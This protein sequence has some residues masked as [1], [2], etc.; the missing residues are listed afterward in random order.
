M[1]DRDFHDA[2]VVGTGFA[3]LYAL[4][5]VK[6]LGLDVK[7]IDAADDVGGTWFCKLASLVDHKKHS[8]NTVFCQWVRLA[9]KRVT[10]IVLD[11]IRLNHYRCLRCYRES[12]SRRPK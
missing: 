7:A 1:T 9:Q 10:H 6:S 3:G 8:Q 12:L 2:L 11:T 5:L 4:Y